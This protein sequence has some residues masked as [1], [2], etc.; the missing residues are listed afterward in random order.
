[1]KPIFFTFAP[2]KNSEDVQ[3]SQQQGWVHSSCF[4]YSLVFNDMKKRD[5]YFLGLLICLVVYAASNRKVC[6]EARGMQGEKNAAQ[7]HPD[8]AKVRAATIF[9]AGLK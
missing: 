6:E 2:Q 7:V 1:M 9:K 8:S 4:L 5:F 3:K